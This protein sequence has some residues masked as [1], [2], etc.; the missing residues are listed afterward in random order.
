MDC[1]VANDAEGMT[2]CFN[3]AVITLA[4]GRNKMIEMAKSVFEIAEGYYCNDDNIPSRRVTVSNFFK[5]V[6]K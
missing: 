5:K 6:T 4:G 1:N 3:K 2:D